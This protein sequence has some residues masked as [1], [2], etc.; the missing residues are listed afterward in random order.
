MDDLLRDFLTESGESLT[1]VDGEMVKLEAEPNNKPTKAIK[2][3]IRG[4]LAQAGQCRPVKLEE[5]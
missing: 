1:I 5:R 4:M 3:V 2:M